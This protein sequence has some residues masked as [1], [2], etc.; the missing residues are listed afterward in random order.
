[1]A[2]VVFP[3]KISNDKRYLVDQQDKPFPILGRTAWFIISQSESGY[4]KFLDNTIAHGHNAIEMAVISHW[5][6]GNHAPF[7]ANRDAPFLKR[8]NGSDWDGKLTYDSIKTEA[9]D[10]LTPNEKYWAFVDDFL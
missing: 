4:K 5:P 7:N 1:R 2:Q 6:M 10:L 8:L 9:P 3:L